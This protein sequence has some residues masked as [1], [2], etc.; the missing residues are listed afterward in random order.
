MN[1]RNPLIMKQQQ[2][3]GKSGVLTANNLTYSLPPDLSVVVERRTVRNFS[4]AT[5]YK[6]GQRA[7]FVLN[8][9]SDFVNFTDSYLTFLVDLD[10]APA[11]DVKLNY[12]D[13][14]SACNLINRITISTRSGDEISRVDNC[15]VLASQLLY[16]DYDDEYH[17]TVA[18]GEQMDHSF[19]GTK[20]VRCVIPLERLSGVFKYDKLAPSVLCSGMRIEILFESVGQAFASDTLEPNV[21]NYTITNPSIV[22]EQSRLTDAVSRAILSE[23]SSNGLE[24]IFHDYFHSLHTTSE[25]VVNA[26]VRK[27]VSRALKIMAVPRITANENSITANSYLAPFEAESWRY[28]LGSQYFPNQPIVGDSGDKPVAES[29]YTTLR[30]FGRHRSGKSAK[31]FPEEF[32]TSHGVLCYPLERQH[33]MDLSGVPVNNSRVLTL[34]CKFDSSKSRL[35]DFYLKRVILA[36]VYLSNTEIEE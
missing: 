30:T 12:N 9:G 14:G 3:N 33:S 8:T 34:D 13:I 23:A 32:T 17:S 10:Q 26:E 1:K 2:Q 36:R 29:Y 4:Q 16:L 25:A 11:G 27:A 7:T 21:T 22:L 31:C 20:P 15:G 24:V 35:I 5:T 28:R 18:S 6:G 19:T